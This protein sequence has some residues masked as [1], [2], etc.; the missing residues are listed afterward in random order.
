MQ[1]KRGDINGENYRRHIDN[2]T[3]GASGEYL[4]KFLLL[5]YFVIGLSKLK[6]VA[7]YVVDYK[8]KDRLKSLNLVD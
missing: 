1:T 3:T 8:A 4:Q 6:K 5:L 7:H 2:L